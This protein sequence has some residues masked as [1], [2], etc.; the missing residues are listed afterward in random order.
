MGEAW[1]Q[2]TDEIYSHIL[3]AQIHILRE[4]EIMSFLQKHLFPFLILPSNTIVASM[5]R[6]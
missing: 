4:R 6:V 1:T 2:T 3:K 5:F